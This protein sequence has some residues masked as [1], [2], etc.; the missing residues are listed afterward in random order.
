[1]PMRQPN[2]FLVNFISI[3]LPPVLAGEQCTGF[4][5]G[6]EE[7]PVTRQS[8]RCWDS[9]FEYISSGEDFSHGLAAKYF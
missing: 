3:G 7:V 1:M 2:S 8:G 5:G 9:C 4:Y 6:C